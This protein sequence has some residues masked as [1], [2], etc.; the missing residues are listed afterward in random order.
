MP[1]PV[2]LAKP[3]RDQRP[4]PRSL[5]E[6]AF[7]AIEFQALPAATKQLLD[8]AVVNVAAWPSSELV[9][10]LGEQETEAL[11]N[12]DG[13][14]SSK[15]ILAYPRDPSHIPAFGTVSTGTSS[16]FDEDAPADA[17]YELVHT[18]P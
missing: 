4:A 16:G 1:V 2:G 10:A 12:G 18:L 9:T 17:I 6:L 13:V 8:E 7:P 14:A 5:A 15:G 3:S 11:V